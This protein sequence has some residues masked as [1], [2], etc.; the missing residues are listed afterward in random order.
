MVGTVK[1]EVTQLLGRAIHRLFHQAANGLAKWAKDVLGNVKVPGGPYAQL[2]M[3]RKKFSLKGIQLVSRPPA[4]SACGSWPAVRGSSMWAGGFFG[5][6]PEVAKD[7][8]FQF[9]SW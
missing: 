2:R 6:T 9:Q 5:L 4:D 3:N 1:A 7:V 8:Y